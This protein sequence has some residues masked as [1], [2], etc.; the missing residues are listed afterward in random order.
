MSNKIKLLQQT[1]SICDEDATPYI[2]EIDKAFRLA[3]SHAAE[4]ELLCTYAPDSEEGQE[5]DI[6]CVCLMED[7]VI[8][9]AIEQFKKNSLP[10]DMLEFKPLQGNFLFKAKRNYHENIICF[11]A[12][13]PELAQ[14]DELWYQAGLCMVYPKSFVGTEDETIL[15]HL[16]DNVVTSFRKDNT[17]A[18]RQNAQLNEFIKKSEKFNTAVSWRF[19]LFSIF[20]IVILL[21]RAYLK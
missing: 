13:S 5:G 4:V 7:N 6:P 14:A 19:I 21:I 9:D 2:Y 20:L 3:K 17:L 11:Y 1:H 10:A 8:W 16:L 18:Q 12:F 15:I